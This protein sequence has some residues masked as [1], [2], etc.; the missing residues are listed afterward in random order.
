MLAGIKEAIK[1]DIRQLGY[2][3]WRVDLPP[4]LESLTPTGDSLSAPPPLDP[5]WP[6]LAV[7]ATASSSRPTSSSR[8]LGFLYQLPEPLEAL[9][10]TRV[11]A[12]DSILLDTAIDRDPRSIIRLVWEDL[13]SFD[14]LTGDR[15]SLPRSRSEP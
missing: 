2:E 3:I 14:Y 13:A 9:R 8:S 11:M 6:F 15:V 4:K 1:K 5:V 10:R 12:R 7:L